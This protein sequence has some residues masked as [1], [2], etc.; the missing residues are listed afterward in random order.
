MTDRA[1]QINTINRQI[2]YYNT[3]DIELGPS[4]I[5]T[6][7]SNSRLSGLNPPTQGVRAKYGG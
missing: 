6:H 7:Q 4:W 2:Y 1:T 3:V 5:H